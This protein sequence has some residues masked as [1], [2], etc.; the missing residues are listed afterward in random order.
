MQSNFLLVTCQVW[1]NPC[2]TVL[3]V[4]AKDLSYA[5]P[6]L[7]NAPSSKAYNLVKILQNLVTSFKWNICPL[8]YTHSSFTNNAAR[9]LIYNWEA[10]F[11]FYH[12]LSAVSLLSD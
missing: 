6:I 5:L 2:I 9:E 8:N 1:Q 10:T 3:G 12:Q 7:G 4:R 11:C